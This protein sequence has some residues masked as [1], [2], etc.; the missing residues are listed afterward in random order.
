MSHFDP[1]T[2]KVLL[3]DDKPANIDVLRD[4][5]QPEGYQLAVALSGEQALSVVERFVPDLILLDIMM[6]G[7]DGYQT[8]RCLKDQENTCRIP[9][10]FITAK[11]EREDILQGFEV[12]CVDY[13]S[14]P[15]H[16]AE[17][18]ARVATH[19]RLRAS[20]RELEQLNQQKDRFLGIVAH[21]LRA[22][23]SGIISYTDIMLED[24]LPAEAQRDCI[25]MVHNTGWQLLGLVNDLLDLSVIE[26]GE[27]VLQPQWGELTPLLR[28]RV[29]IYQFKAAHRHIR[30][31]AEYAPL[32][33]FYFDPNRMIQVVD[34]LIGNALKF[35]PAGS[36][37]KLRLWCEQEHV[38]L[39]VSDQ[40]PGLPEGMRPFEFQPG[41]AHVASGEKSTGF[42]LAIMKK[43]IDAHHGTVTI[44]STP[45]QGC[46]FTV[47]LP[48]RRSSD[49]SFG[50]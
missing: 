33:A 37:V 35:S 20:L 47:R 32:R 24:E 28:Q 13:I 44:D 15:F 34:N 21:D 29:K 31:H 50:V 9:I 18:C 36:E 4:T 5:L 11:T 17:V 26:R 12:G 23:L 14:K 7:L 3:V 25:E 8:C 45:G 2:M 41:A 38:Y 48:Y 1:T 19:L 49:A 16:R 40:G 27:L 43:I 22:P 46:A 42:G 39:R 10:I 30:L 6:P